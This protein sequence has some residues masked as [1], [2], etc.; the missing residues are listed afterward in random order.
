MEEKTAI[1]ETKKNK[2]KYS[3]LFKKNKK[4]RPTSRLLNFLRVIFIPFYFLVK[5]FRFYGKNKVPK[6]ACVFVGNH[7]TLFDIVYPACLTWEGIH[8]LSK[9][10]NIQTYFR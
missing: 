4:G 2:K 8:F 5:P 7:Y 3:I 9:K 1:T 10:E 6:G